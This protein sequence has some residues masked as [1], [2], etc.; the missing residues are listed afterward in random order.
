M[1]LCG[2]IAAAIRSAVLVRVEQGGVGVL[3]L[4]PGA[5]ADGDGGP[6]RLKR[7][8]PPCP[9]TSGGARRSVCGNERPATKGASM[10]W[11]LALSGAVFLTSFAGQLPPA[12]TTEDRPQPRWPQFHGPLGSGVAEDDG[13]APVE[14][15]PDARLLWRTPVPGGHSSPAIWG[16]RIFITAF[17]PE[18]TRLETLCLDRTTGRILW[19]AAAPTTRIEKVHEISS[20]AAPTPATDGRTVFVYFG[21][22]GLIAYDFEGEVR[23]SKP[24]PLAETF[25]DFGSGTSPILLGDRLLLDVHLGQESHLLAVRTRDGEAVWK[26]PKPEFNLGWTTPVAWREGEDTVVGVLN[27]GRFTAHD[28]EDGRERWW[29]RDLPRQ[30]CATPVVGNGLLFLSASGVQGGIENLTPPPSFDEVIARY[31]RDKDGRIHLD[32]LPETLMFTD[33]KA[34]FGAGDTTLRKAIAF[35]YQLPSA[36]YDRLA[37]EKSVQSLTEFAKGP[38]MESA[39]LAVR[40]GGKGDVTGSHVLWAESKGVPEVPSPLLY[41]DRLYLVKNGGIVTCR[42]ATTGRLVYEGRLGAQGGYYASPIAAGG[43]IY[44][45]TDQGVVVV[46]QSGDTLRVLARNDLKEPIMATPAI[47]EGRLYVRTAGHVYSFGESSL[48]RQ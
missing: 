42:E 24:L 40:S 3:D 19:R 25:R 41:R 38:L 33:R 45:A 13:S 21:S 23:W 28:V 18:E 17:R 34:T 7:T 44:A 8:F 29:I 32:E 43:R 9:L 6:P 31:D 5:G 10:K 14:F 15:G 37:W 11:R 26:A 1:T 47:V 35:G 20:P 36:T 2:V 22:Y 12:P 39:V 48:S 27:A 30:A 16:D 4:P 46:F